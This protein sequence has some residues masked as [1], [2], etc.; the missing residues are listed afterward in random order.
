MTTLSFEIHIELMMRFHC[1]LILC[2][3]SLEPFSQIHIFWYSRDS[4]IESSRGRG[5]PRYHFSGVHARSLVRP[6][7]GILELSGQI[8]HIRC[9]TGP[10]LPHLAREAI[11]LSQTLHSFHPS[12]GIYYICLTNRYS[13]D[14]RRDE[15]SME[16][17]VRVWIATLARAIQ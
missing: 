2:G 6:R 12:A 3:A 11:V 7:G 13:C 10:Y 16:H 5:F 15:F 9:H 17:D 14:F 8:R 4:W 1:V